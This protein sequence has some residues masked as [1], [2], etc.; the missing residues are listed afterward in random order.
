MQTSKL[1]MLCLC[2][3]M[4]MNSNGASIELSNNLSENGDVESIKIEPNV[5]SIQKRR[6][7]KYP[8]IF[9]VVC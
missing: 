9:S 7:R 5:H 2:L 6:S 4:V 1:L 3:M 8:F